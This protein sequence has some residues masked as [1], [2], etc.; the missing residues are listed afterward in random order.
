MISKTALTYRVPVGIAG[1]IVALLHFLF[2]GF[3]VL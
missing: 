2:P 3:A 1:I